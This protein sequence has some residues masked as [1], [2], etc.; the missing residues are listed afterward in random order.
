[1]ETTW[2]AVMAALGAFMGKPGVAAAMMPGVR[3]A[4]TTA[5]TAVSFFFPLF[6]FFFIIW[7]VL[8]L[9]DLNSVFG[10]NALILS[11]LPISA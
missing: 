11:C 10:F 4:A 2:A 1:M 5:L 8:Y 3:L 9:L 7:K 6:L